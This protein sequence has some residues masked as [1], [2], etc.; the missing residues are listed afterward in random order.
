MLG[1][2]ITAIDHISARDLKSNSPKEVAKYRE[3]LY[4][5]LKAHNIF[6]QLEWL[7]MTSMTNWTQLHQA[8]LNEIDD[9]ITEGMLSA[10]KKASLKRHLPWSP[11]LQAAQIE[12]EY[13][14]KIISGIC[15]KRHFAV[16]IEQLL[17]KL[18][19]KLQ[20]C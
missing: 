5:H 17:R 14:L 19:Q 3:C 1:E 4:G 18:P 6:K 16:Q 12:V 9:R 8:E 13:S 10:E 11:D 7:D 20:E 15:N 2:N